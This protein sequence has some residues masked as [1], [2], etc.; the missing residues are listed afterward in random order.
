[1]QIDYAPAGS[2]TLAAM[3]NDQAETSATYA[4]CGQQ[5]KNMNE[6][7]M[8]ACPKCKGT[9][10]K[11][12]YVPYCWVVRCDYCKVSIHGFDQEHAERLWREVAGG[13]QPDAIQTPK[14]STLASATGYTALELLQTMCELRRNMD[15]AV[16]EIN[17]ESY[18]RAALYLECAASKLRTIQRA[19]DAV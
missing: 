18:A 12:Y 3:P 2:K 16:D 15:A 4:A 7:K 17:G 8:P 19:V 1:M 6:A 9:D 10:I 13:R 14:P 5:S 11:S